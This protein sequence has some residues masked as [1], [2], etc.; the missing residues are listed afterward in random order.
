MRRQTELTPA[1]YLSS[2]RGLGLIAAW[3]LAGGCQL[4]A[5][6]DADSFPPQDVA[7][8]AGG[9]GAAS[10]AGTAGDGP[11]RQGGA[12]TGGAGGGA[13][14]ASGAGGTGAG[15]AGGV[16]PRLVTYVATGNG[17]SCAIVD[18]GKVL[19]WGRNYSGQ[20]GDGTIESRYAPTPVLQSPG[21]SPLTGAQ[22]LA[23][24]ESHSCALLVGGEVRCW[25]FNN[26]GRLGDGTIENRLTPVTV[27]QSL[28]GP[29]LTGVLRVEL[30]ADYSCA[31]RNDGQVHCWGYNGSGQLGNNT[32]TEQLTPAPVLQAPGGGPVIDAKG[33]AIG[34]RHGCL[35]LANGQA[36]CWGNN[37]AGQLGDGTQDNRLTPV[38]VLQS[39]GGPPLTGIQELALG[40]DHSCARLGGG[41][42][43]CWGSNGSGQLGDGTTESRLTP[44]TVLQSPGGSALTGVQELTLGDASSCARL[45][46]GNVRC[47]GSNNTGQLGDGTKVNQLTPVLML[48]AQ[49]GSPLA[50][51]Q[52]VA[53]GWYH[54]C[55]RLAGDDVRCWGAN[56]S[57]QLGD[58]T[59]APQLTPVRVL[60]P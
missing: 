7:G 44:T 47:W 1:P 46:G 56:D 25:G 15:G 14:G 51:V 19:C 36:R 53:P 54:S 12:G 18:E 5:G 20:L 49:G 10:G 6:V 41:E 30:G 8:A 38:L 3:L 32:N 52:G 2:R 11:A 50:G 42:V 23:L 45:A 57:G 35:G 4:L 37:N 33:M 13:A 28:G 21:G 31:L 16:A 26:S 27:V 59:T 29:P 34:E 22:Q 43:R 9:F 17:Y 58:G 39:P 40:E 24:S 60:F 55:A 48:E